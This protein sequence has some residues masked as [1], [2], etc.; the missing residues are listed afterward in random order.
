[1]E[2]AVQSGTG[3]RA[4]VSG[5]TIAGKTGS[6]ENKGLY[7]TGMS[8]YYS[9]A[10]W[11]GHDE[12]KSLANSTFGGAYSAPIFQRFMTTIH[13]EKGLQDKAIIE[14][15]PESLGLVK[16]TVCQ[17]SGMKATDACTHDA[18]GLTPVTD[19]FKAGTEPTE[20]CT[21]HMSLPI[22]TESGKYATPYCP[23][24][25]GSASQV[26]VPLDSVLRNCDL[27]GLSWYHLTGAS[28]FNYINN[29]DQFCPLHTMPG[30]TLAPSATP[31]TDPSATPS[32]VI[33]SLPIFTNTPRPTNT[34]STGTGD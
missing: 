33:P 13:R 11:I 27:S 28:D 24:T 22:C 25:T 34:P 20:S 31:S 7:F 26:F 8:P 4:Q 16:A 23:S 19:W 21:Y 6:N 10:V 32:A 14:D 12:Y 3:S 15:S 18:G 5:M 30:A 17:V 9:A 2:T 29:P 1:M